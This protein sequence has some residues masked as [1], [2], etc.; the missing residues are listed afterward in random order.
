M[1]RGK[2][3]LRD[4]KVTN[5]FFNQVDTFVCPC[6]DNRVRKHAIE[7]MKPGGSSDS[8]PPE[9]DLGKV[10]LKCSVFGT[11]RWVG[12][13]MAV[14]VTSFLKEMLTSENRQKW[15]SLY[16]TLDETP[17]PEAVKQALKLAYDQMNHTPA[18]ADM[19]PPMDTFDMSNLK[20]VAKTYDILCKINE[21]DEEH[22]LAKLAG[23][24][25]NLAVTA[26]DVKQSSDDRLAAKLDVLNLNIQSKITVPL[27]S[28]LRQVQ[29]FNMDKKLDFV[30]EGMRAL[31]Y[32]DKKRRGEDV[33]GELKLSF[34]QKLNNPSKL[35]ESAS[36]QSRKRNKKKTSLDDALVKLQRNVQIT[37]EELLL[38]KKTVSDAEKPSKLPSPPSS[39]TYEGVPVPEGIPD[40]INQRFFDAAFAFREVVVLRQEASMQLRRVQCTLATW[41]N[42][43]QEIWYVHLK[44][45]P[46]S[47]A[48]IR[49]VRNVFLWAKLVLLCDTTLG[50]IR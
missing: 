9:V 20:E 10:T 16:D 34:R 22:Q 48:G 47:S 30:E 3:A 31:I 11:N 46:S 17:D 14:P 2:K 32:G 37:T 5:E 7:N 25:R 8:N 18:M 21:N 29:L 45:A 36:K 50:P 42:T 1:S 4:S 28:C 43:S 19:F 24:I 40:S 26:G 23:R 39:F 35:M 33:G 13:V 27:R 49:D 6:C 12:Q 15:Q 38:L 44:S 41:Y